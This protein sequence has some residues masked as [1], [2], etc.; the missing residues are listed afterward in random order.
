M[1]TILYLLICSMGVFTVA[2]I[3]FVVVAHFVHAR[4]MKDANCYLDNM[5]EQWQVLI[6]KLNLQIVSTLH[7]SRK[8]YAD[9]PP[10]EGVEVVVSNTQTGSFVRISAHG[11]LSRDLVKEKE[12]GRE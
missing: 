7:E 8:K 4:W 3:V 5:L 10:D 2:V 1:H 6:E 11:P 12:K 9:L